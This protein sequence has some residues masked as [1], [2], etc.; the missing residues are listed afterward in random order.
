[1]FSMRTMS[2]GSKLNIMCSMF[3]LF[4]PPSSSSPSSSSPS[5]LSPQSSFSHAF[6][7]KGVFRLLFSLPC[8]SFSPPPTSRNGG[9]RS[10]MIPC[11]SHST[12]MPLP[13]HRPRPC[14]CPCLSVA[15]TLPSPTPTS[16]PTPM[17]CRHRHHRHLTPCFHPCL[18][19]HT[20]SRLLRYIIVTY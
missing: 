5:S 12:P 16:S 20:R 2:R 11:T 8:R 17:R 3:D 13:S 9:H 14:P 1:M 6:L 4:F 18:C 7:G 19:P 10:W 15:L